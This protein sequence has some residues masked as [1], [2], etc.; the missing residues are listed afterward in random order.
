MCPPDGCGAESRSAC[1]MSR[2]IACPRQRGR[3]AIVG[4]AKDWPAR[5]RQVRPELVH[6]PRLG[7]ERRAGGSFLWRP[8]R[9]NASEPAAVW[10]RRVGRRASAPAP[11]SDDS[12]QGRCRSRLTAPRTARPRPRRCRSWRTSRPAKAALRAAA[13][14]WV[15]PA[16][17]TPDV[18]ASSRCT[19]RGRL[20][21]DLAKA[22]A[23]CPASGRP[24]CASAPAGR[25]AC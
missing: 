25:T 13:A 19:R 9:A 7:S 22:P 11:A 2:G 21:F 15:L 16:M 6:P 24:D 12:A 1:S 5:Q 20:P 8:A 23:A 14:G 4:I 18:W 10:R 3:A 17:M